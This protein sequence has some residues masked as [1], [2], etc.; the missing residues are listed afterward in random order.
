MLIF[1]PQIISVPKNQGLTNSFPSIE[2]TKN[3][4]DEFENTD[5][6]CDSVTEC[7]DHSDDDEDGRDV[8]LSSFSFGSL[9]KLHRFPLNSLVDE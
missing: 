1:G 2:I 8:D 5:E 6:G 3:Y 7:V 4:V 9:I